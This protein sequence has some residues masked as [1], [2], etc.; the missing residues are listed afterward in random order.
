VPRKPTEPPVPVK[1]GD[2]EVA[3]LEYVW[4]SGD[5]AAKE[6]HAALGTARGISLNTVQ[7]AMERLFRKGLLTRVKASHS[8]R[9]SARV[10]REE[11]VAG[12]IGEVL[13]RFGADSSAALAA[14]VEAADD[15]DESALRALEAELRKR[16]Q[17]GRPK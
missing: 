16:R 11:L 2:L 4:A 3:V 7:S 5:V 8:F 14:F 1:L 12:L 9:Y 17:R 15:L 10:G 6:A 13:G